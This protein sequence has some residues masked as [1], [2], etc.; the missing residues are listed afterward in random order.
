MESS[1]RHE[2]AYTRDTPLEGIFR[3][4]IARILDFLILNQD[5]DYSPAEMSRITGIPTRTVQRA[6]AHLLGKRLIK[7]T[8]SV[9]NSTMFIL[10]SESPLAAAL[11][12]YIV[13]AI[14]QNVETLIQTKVKN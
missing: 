13:A 7:E 5:F 6:I 1:E 2:V 14:N 4:S 10:N 8:R 11:R 3:N 9:G 12:N